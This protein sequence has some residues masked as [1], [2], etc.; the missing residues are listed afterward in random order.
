[1]A[2]SQLEILARA[3]RLAGSLAGGP[4]RVEKNVL[5]SVVADFMSDPRPDLDRLRRT[6][7][8]IE[9]GSGGHL[10]RSDS[11]RDQVRAVARELGETLSE[12]D[13]DSAGWKSLFGWTAR[14]LL[15]RGAPA[16]SRPLPPDGLNGPGSKRSEPAAK[17]PF[18]KPGPAGRLSGIGSKSLSTLEQLKRKLA[19]R[20]EDKS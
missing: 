2:L 16:P 1:M 6:L 18:T 20:G 7:Q 4:T 9:Q 17:R 3:E 19:D 14:L 15:V 11:Y 8:L 10:L 12:L 13:L 5:L